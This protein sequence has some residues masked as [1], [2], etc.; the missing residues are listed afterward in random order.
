MNVI[1]VSIRSDSQREALISPTNIVGEM[2]VSGTLY[3]ITIFFYRQR[4]LAVNAHDFILI[5]T[6]I[7]IFNWK[8]SEP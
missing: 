4:Q 8:R 6:H 3:S 2:I 1:I 7:D 5:S